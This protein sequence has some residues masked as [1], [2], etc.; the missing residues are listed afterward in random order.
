MSLTHFPLVSTANIIWKKVLFI[1][2]N[3]YH[4]DIPTAYALRVPNFQGNYHFSAVTVII[5]YPEHQNAKS[6]KD[7]AIALVRSYGFHI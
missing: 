1:Y 5:F 2:E 3:S 4:Y 6:W 7:P